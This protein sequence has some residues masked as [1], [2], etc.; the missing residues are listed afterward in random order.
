MATRQTRGYRIGACISPKSLNGRGAQSKPLYP[1]E[2]HPNNLPDVSTDVSL[3]TPT[4]PNN[5]QKVFHLNI[6]NFIKYILYFHVS[7]LQ[8]LPVYF[9]SV[10]II[11]M[12][13][14]SPVVPQSFHRVVPLRVVQSLLCSPSPCSASVQFLL[15]YSVV[16]LCEVPH[17]VFPPRC[18]VAPRVGPPRVVQ[19]PL[20]VLL[21]R[22]IPPRVIPPRI[23]S[24]RVIPLRVIPLRVVPPYAVSPY[25][26]PLRVVIS[27]CR[28]SPCN[29]P[30][31]WCSS[32]SV[33][34]LPEQSLSVFCVVPSSV[35][36]L[37]M[38]FHPRVVCSP[39]SVQ[40]CTL[41]YIHTDPK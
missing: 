12:Q 22:V 9:L 10:Q 13:S 32:S 15:V 35:Q 11:H 38:Q 28:S 14:L 6:C 41:H 17:R 19:S 1:D 40:Y 8:S 37:S 31:V 36:S 2:M 3:Y 39:P 25:I 34:S 7:Q 29:S 20:C 16:A 21:P 30:F 26:V 24:P 5:S 33:Q 4:D 27:L 18:V 23:I